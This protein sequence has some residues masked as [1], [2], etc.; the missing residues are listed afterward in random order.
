MKVKVNTTSET[1]I[2]LLIETPEEDVLKSMEEET[3]KL[4]K[5]ISLPGF[6][7]GKVPIGMIRSQYAAQIGA[8]AIESVVNE[9]YKEA[10]DQEDLH[11]I[12]PGNISDIDYDPGKPLKFK[13]VIEIEPVFELRDCKDIKVEKV[14]LKATKEMLEESLKKV[15]Y[16]YATV[17]TKEE[18]AEMGNHIVMDM[19]EVDPATGVEII[20]KKYPETKIILG[21]NMIGNDID[22]QIV[23]MK[24]GETKLIL[25]K[26]L[27][28]VII[29]PN[30]DKQEGKI[31][32]FKISVSKIESVTLPEINDEL[33]KEMK[34]ETVDEMRTGLE[35]QIQSELDNNSRNQFLR[36][37][38]E[39]I[40]QYI[41]PPIPDSMLDNYLNK[42]VENY[43]KFSKTPIEI[44]QVKETEKD[45][46]K[47]RLQ[48]LLIR[49]KLVE[50]EKMEVSDEEL[51]EYIKKYAEDHGIEYERLK[52]EY[53]S[54][55]KREE[56]RQNM[57]DDKVYEYY[58]NQIKVKTI[59]Q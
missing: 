32:N 1:T 46:A 49:E 28:Q 6:R 35:K 27:P 21:E 55:Q 38:E 56:L 34:F 59:K 41:N 19:Q 42:M 52:I 58:E 37:M 36:T 43:Q 18:A 3:E 10:I 15:Q 9:K 51:D 13:A 44:D 5:K 17:Q 50:Q 12:T 11:P 24:A 29:D 31:E 57:I 39:S 14:V 53:R 26:V 7:K 8:S 30:Q 25:H 40:A 22:E 16:R 33:A 54:G 20:G 47:L 4:R 23:G 2:E 45:R 48:W